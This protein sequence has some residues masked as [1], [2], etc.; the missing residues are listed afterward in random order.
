MRAHD[1][2]VT[3]AATTDSLAEIRLPAARQVVDDE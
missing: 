2:T 3:L 1:L